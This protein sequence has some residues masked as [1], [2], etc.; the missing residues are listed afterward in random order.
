MH[1]PNRM[2]I[3]Q[4]S[5]EARS[6]RLYPFM[7]CAVI[8][9]VLALMELRFPYFFLQDDNRV[10]HLPLYVHNLRALM[11]G[12]FPFYNFHQYLGTPVGI[13]SAVLYPF[14]YAGLLFSKLLLGHYLGAIEFI[15]VIHLLIAGLGM[16]FLARS[17]GLGGSAG[18]FGGFAYAFCG[19]LITFGNSWIQTLDCAAYLPWLL[20]FGLRLAAGGGPGTFLTLVGIRVLALLIGYPQLYVYMATFEFITVAALLVSVRFAIPPGDEDGQ[21]AAGAWRRGVLPYVLSHVT[22]LMVS[23]PLLLSAY[24]QASVSLTRKAALDWKQYSASSYDLKLWLSGLVAPLSETGATWNELHFISHIGYLTLFTMAAAVWLVRDSSARRQM[25]VFAGCAAVALLWSG[26]T[27]VTRMVYHLPIFNK[28]KHPFKLALFP[29]FYMIIIASFGFD[30]IC[31]R[32]SSTRSGRVLILVMLALHVGNFAVIYLIPRQHSFAHLLDRVPFDEPLK[33]PLSQGRIVSVWQ[34]E[35]NDNQ[36]G[37]AEG[38]T[39]PLL[40]YDYAT[41]WGLYHLGGH[42]ALVSE[43]NFIAA[44]RLSYE[45]TITI[46]DGQTMDMTKI[47][48]EY[49]RNWGVHWYVVDKVVPVDTFG[50]LVL[51]HE[52]VFRKIYFDPAG[53]P[54]AFWAGLPDAPAVRHEFR[55]NSIILTTQRTTGGTL[56]INV[57]RNPFFKAEIDGRP[58]SISE[59]NTKQ[60]LIDVPGGE[61]SVVVS[62]ADRYFMKGLPI[63]LISL[64]VMLGCCRLWRRR[65]LQCA[66]AMPARPGG[67]G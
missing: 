22:A 3:T 24:H 54:F 18:L 35:I 29:A 36:L 30:A 10:Q 52:D 51:F 39:A 16:F 45:S 13:Q 5:E 41:L 12:E 57:L 26:D 14:N 53:K 33:E 49:F 15:A 27:F 59:T 64:A 4:Q 6:W 11:N 46:P 62:Y 34:R 42:D 38:F 7:L 63:S 9:C 48:L 55:T 8:L 28:F 17:L 65:E 66:A 44:F 2:T 25:L 67:V 19:Y 61:H 50:G 56:L 31:R 58:V 37:K 32:T 43:D 1:M 60:V 47:P 23:M 40:G 20:L 21:V